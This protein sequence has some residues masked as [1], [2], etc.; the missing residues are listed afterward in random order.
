VDYHFA[1][2]YWLPP[3]QF[4][5]HLSKSWCICRRPAPSSPSPPRRRLSRCRR[6]QPGQL[7]FGSFNRLGKIN[8][9]NHSPLVEAVACA[10]RIEVDHRGHPAGRSAHAVDGKIRRGRGRARAAC[11]SFPQRIDTYLALHHQVDLCLDTF[12]YNGGTTTH[13]ALWMGVPTLTIAGTT[14]AGR[15]GAAL[16]GL[17]GLD[18]FIATDAADFV[19]KGL[20]WAARLDTLAEL[21]T[22]LR[23]LCGN[24]RACSR[25]FLSQCS[26]VR[27][28]ACGRA[29][30]PTCRRNRLK[31]RRRIS[32]RDVAGTTVA[33]R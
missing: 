25:T 3:G 1:D 11:F 24:P 29:G 6:S 18:E 14:P 17:M 16:L 12:P 22:G 2:R 9:A 19:A 23:E 8:A 4:D 5:R 33:G 13:H 28:G 20:Y 30:A 7:T 10:A 27:C 31:F 15:Q 26:N 21:R 32:S